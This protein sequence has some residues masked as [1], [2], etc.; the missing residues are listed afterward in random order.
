MV[1]GVDHRDE[2]IVLETSRYRI[3][4][5]LRLPRDGYRSRLTDYLNSSERAFLPLTDV[6]IIP[7]EGERRS[8]RRPFLALS[9][10][11][12]VLA[13]PADAGPAEE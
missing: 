12:I 6:E 13:M 1:A 4:G 9:I 7:L 2:R 11:Q 5:V 10:R 8:E 3:S